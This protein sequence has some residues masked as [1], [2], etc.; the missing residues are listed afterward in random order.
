VAKVAAV[1]V[2]YNNAAMLAR[3]LGELSAQTLKPS[4]VVVI[5]N[6]ST[7]ATA[8]LFPHADPAAEYARLPENSG[9]AGGFCEGIRRALE[10]EC[11]FVLTLDD[12]VEPARDCVEKLVAGFERLAQSQRLAAVRAVGPS[13]EAGEPTPI[14]IAPWRGTLFSAA[15]LREIGLPDAGCFLYGE[16]LEYSL[17][18]RRK[19]YELLWMPGAICPERRQGKTD[20]TLLGRPVKIYPSA[21]RLYYAFRNEVRIFRA[22]GELLKLA[23]TFLY[24]LKVTVYLAIREGAAGAGKRRAVLTGI[25]DGLRGRRGKNPSYPPV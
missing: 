21:F 2:A 24:A 4:R 11:G 23:R 12:D 9:S 5:D 1:V 15:A 6:A 13:H 22:Y 25:A 19:G 17:R 14:D 16:D 20:D 8:A 3:L 18:L 7:D 10:G